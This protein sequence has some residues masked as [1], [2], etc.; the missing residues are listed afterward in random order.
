LRAGDGHEGRPVHVLEGA[1]GHIAREHHEERCDEQRQPVDGAKAE[2][3][4]GRHERAAGDREDPLRRRGGDI[5]RRGQVAGASE[6][7]RG[8][9]VP[10]QQYE[11]EHEVD[12]PRAGH[13][14]HVVHDHVGREPR[15][16]P[17]HGGGHRHDAQDEA[18]DEGGTD[19]A[20]Q[21]QGQ[22][23]I[24][25]DIEPRQRER[26]ADANERDPV[27]RHGLALGNGRGGV[28]LGHGVES[29]Q[30]VAQPFQNEY[31][32]PMP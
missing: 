16:G 20:A 32:P 3:G 2:H 22:G 12:E 29:T 9:R 10:P 25:P 26:D 1:V 14:E 23:E 24:G 4:R 13:A 7:L 8:D 21:P 5:I 17:D 28:R 30:G 27:A 15:A 18:A 31:D 11:R 6:K 19:G